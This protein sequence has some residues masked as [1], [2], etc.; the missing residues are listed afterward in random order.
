MT[1]TLAV[2]AAVFFLGSKIKQRVKLFQEFFIPAPVIG[3]ILMSAL[4]LA[5]RHYGIL[6]IS[7][8]TTLQSLFMTA[9]F[10]TVGFMASL[11]LMAKGG[12][13][14]AVMLLVSGLLLIAQN[15]TGC[16][17]AYLFGLDPKFGL[18]VGSV[19]L[20]GGH[21]T[22]GAFG[23]TI[24]EMGIAGAQSA[25]FAAATYGLIVGCLIGGP[26]GRVLMKRF[27][28]VP[29]D[30]KKEAEILQSEP[31]VDVVGP[32]VHPDAFS[33]NNLMNAAVCI[34]VSMG[35]GSLVSPFVKDHTHWLMDGGLSLPAY[36][37]PMLVA[38]LIRNISDFFNKNIPMVAIDAL[39]SISLSIFLSMAMMTMKLWELTELALP[40]VAILSAQTLLVISFVYLVTFRV[41]RMK[42]LGTPY[43]SA[44]I[45]AGHC[46]FGLG[47]T[48]T[49]VANMTAFCEANGFS[50]KAFFIIPLIGALFIDFANALIISFFLNFV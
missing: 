41:M 40:I 33:G 12:L 4:I 50:T 17:M 25:G 26:V 44:V 45:C 7:F 8:D 30:D 20:T 48:P 49:A 28:I 35:I 15:V 3:G 46:G 14:V 9:F 47:A 2:A 10:T 31:A 39:G 6:T 11:R 37:G 5:L 1:Q 16:S 27:K 19:S 32:D 22:V 29:H 21:G 38:A 23:A 24:E 42:F 18:M 13:G 36:I 34:A 43:D